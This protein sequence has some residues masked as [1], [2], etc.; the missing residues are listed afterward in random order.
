MTEGQAEGHALR[1]CYIGM[2]MAASLPLTPVERDD[3]YYMLLLKDIGCSS[4]AARICQLFLADDLAFK[5]D[6]KTL[7]E[8]LPQVLH[9]VFT[10]TGLKAGLAERFRALVH[11]FTAGNITHGLIETRCQ[12]GAEIARQM[13]FSDAV[14]HGIL[15]LDEHWDGRGLPLG[16][17]GK[18]ISPLAQI[19]LLAQVADVFHTASGPAAARREIAQRS[20]KWF[21]PAL[22]A[23]FA[24]IAADPAFWQR[25]ASPDM[26]RIVQD[27]A[28]AEAEGGV[29]EDFLDDVAA[30]FA[31]VVDAK[32]PFTSGHS[33][34]VALFADLIAEELGLSDEHR[35]HL[36]RAGLLHD[37][38]KLGVS[39]QI[40]DK[41]GKP[42]DDEWV[43]I[44]SHPG[45]GA[46]ILS[47]ITAFSDLAIVAASHHERLDGRGYP[48]GLTAEALGLDTRI[49]SVADVFDA[50]TAD[51]P[52]RPAM[53]IDKAFSIMD[54]DVG[55][56]FDPDCYA[57]LKRALDRAERL[58]SAAA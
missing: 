42:D 44:R 16:R 41:N 51:R 21:D 17:K 38:G 32:S 40:L 49:I 1:C 36:K 39:N 34:R 48:H 2:T 26:E 9:F 53:P 29:A 24:A 35:R 30:A 3:L 27:L 22:S 37:I 33:K 12:R 6:F 31:E 7:N 19:A 54:R 5:R 57:A 4:N 23:R 15:D 10:H 25:L 56:A 8:S 50:L 55:L 45:L 18:E 52:Y 47:R 58:R 14:A 13:R 20:G 43:A 11:T 28:P 46:R